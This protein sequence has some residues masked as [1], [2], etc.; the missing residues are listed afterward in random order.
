MSLYVGM[1]PPNV[2][3]VIVAA[4][5]D[6]DPLVAATASAIDFMATSPAGVAK[7][8]SATATSSSASQIE[9][10]HTLSPSD[11]DEAGDWRLWVRFTLPGMGG[12]L[13]TNTGYLP[14]V[15]DTNA[16]P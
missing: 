14:T 5:V 15:L 1:G 4:S 6:F 9:V 16:V 13:R 8:W 11:L 3:R 2:I 10:E 12:V 7:T